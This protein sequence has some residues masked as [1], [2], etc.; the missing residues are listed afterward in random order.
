MNA[1][2]ISYKSNIRIPNDQTV[3]IPEGT[4]KMI[5]AQARP[6][7][8]GHVLDCI[9]EENTTLTMPNGF[10]LASAVVSVRQYGR[11]PVQICNYSNTNIKLKPKTMIGCAMTQNDS[12][13][14]KETAEV[15][16]Q[17]V[18]VCPVTNND[19]LGKM[20]VGS[21]TSEQQ[22]QLKD[23]ISKYSDTLSKGEDDIGFFELQTAVLNEHRVDEEQPDVSLLRCPPL[24]A[25]SLPTFDPVEMAELQKADPTIKRLML[26][27]NGDQTATK[28]QFVRE[29]KE[30]RKL[31]NITKYLKKENGIL[32]K[33]NRNAKQLLLPN[34]LKQK[35]LNTAHDEMGHQCFERTF[36]IIRGKC[37][38]PYMYTEIADYCDTCERCKVGKLGRTVKTTFKSV[39]AKRLLDIVAID[40]TVLER[41]VGGLENV[42]VITDIFTKYTQAIPTRDQKAKTVAR[43]LLKEWI[44]RFGAPQRLHSDQ[45]RS[46]EN[47]II[48]E[49]CKIYGVKKTKTLPYYPEG[50]SVCE[51][52]NRTMHNLLR[53]TDKKSRWPELLPELVYAYNC[54]PHSTT[55]Y[56]P[57]FLF[58]GR[59][60]TIPLDQLLGTEQEVTFEKE[61]WITEHFNNLKQAFELA[62]DRTEKQALS[63]QTTLNKKVD[64]KELP[65]GSRVFLRN[66]PKGRAKIQDAWNSKPFR[67]IEKHENIYKVEPLLGRGEPKNVHRREMLDAR[68]LVRKDNPLIEPPQDIRRGTCNDKRL[69]NGEEEDD[70]EYVV[71]MQIPPVEDLAS[72]N[73]T[74]DDDEVEPPET[75]NP[76]PGPVVMEDNDENFLDDISIGMDDDVEGQPETTDV[77]EKPPILRKSTRI[78]AGK[79]LNPLNLPRSVLQNEISIDT[80]TVI[81]KNVLQIF[82]N[83]NCFWLIFWRILY[84]SNM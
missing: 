37:Y 26:Y 55:G 81:D 42:L 27:I 76:L 13:H 84:Q 24:I 14:D 40:F 32:Y 3:I 20:D 63:R 57:Y 21:L 52:F 17:T 82:V 77:V 30:V 18:L 4:I 65:V 10:Q 5:E 45:G 1:N 43:I 80:T 61:E 78:T 73:V 56:S 23:V 71:V 51:R 49:L 36:D 33:V 29:T 7:P 67:I 8:K 69:I 38:W 9:V 31:V 66:H 19:Y 39:L 64:N 48:H 16:S 74:E 62:A 72:E 15:N 44:I 60:P 54:T 79:H 6:A 41:G 58:F 83:H 12:A 22:L 2:E 70:E 68:Y 35:V 11:I 46:F 34:A 75:E 53:T 47:E 50:N 25:S 59:E 28:R